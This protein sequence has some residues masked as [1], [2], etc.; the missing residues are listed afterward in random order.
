MPSM[1]EAAAFLWVS[2]RTLRRRPLDAGTSYRD[3]ARN[4]KRRWACS[5]LRNR[6]YS[7]KEVAI[8]L[9]F[10]DLYARRYLP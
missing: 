7:P 6:D 5:L 4:A 2:T 9:G 10:Q 1:A 8:M 3:L